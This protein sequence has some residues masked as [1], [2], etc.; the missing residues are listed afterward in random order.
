MNKKVFTFDKETHTYLLDGVK[1]PSVTEIISPLSDF[2]GVNPDVLKRAG[3]YGTATHDM[4]KFWLDGDLDEDLLDAEL[5]GPLAAFKKWVYEQTSYVLF[6]HWVIE[7]PKYHARLKYAGTADIVTPTMLIDIKTRAYNPI[8]DPLQ[9]AAYEGLWETKT[10]RD[11]Y[12]L[13]LKQ[14][15][16]YVFTKANRM[17]AWPM[18][19]YLLDDWYHQQEVA[20]KIKGWKEKR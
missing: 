13:E 8:T 2:S 3:D 14:D 20:A 15:G 11:K 7:M 10:K 19:R 17:Q 9:L 6:N 16:S 18:F 12:I 4:I 1:L 5:K